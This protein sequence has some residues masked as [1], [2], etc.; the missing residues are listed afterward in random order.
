MG[1]ALPAAVFLSGAAALIYQVCWQRILALHTGIGLFSVAL[2]VGAFMAGL[3]LGSL[4]GGGL[5]ERFERRQALLAFAALELLIGLFG[6]LSV[7]IY[8]DW[9]YLGHAALYGQSWRAVLLHFAALLPPT[10]LMGMSLPFLTRATV[11]SADTAARAVAWVYGINVLGAAFGSV[12]APWWLIRSHGMRT[13]V[14]VAAVANLLAAAA[15]LAAARAPARS[16]AVETTA[17]LV[18]GTRW[19]PLHWMA[20]YALSGFV[21]LSLEM[22]W[23]R[24]LDIAVRATAFTFGTLLAIYLLGNAAGALGARFMKAG[25]HGP[26]A[27]FIACQCALLALSALALAALVYAPVHWPLVSWLADIWDGS[28]SFNLGGAWDGGSVF[29]LYVLLPALLFGLPTILMGV[30]MA[31]LQTAV[32]DDPRTSGFKVGWL[33]AANIAGCVAGALFAGIV[34][35]NSLGTTGTLR[36]LVACAFVFLAFGFRLLPAARRSFAAWAA[37]IAAVLMV[38]PGQDRFWLRFHG[39]MPGRSLVEEDATGVVALTPGRHDTWAMWV[40]GKHFSTLPYGGTH[41]LLGALPSMMHA[42]P[43]RIALI[44]LGSGDTAWASGSRSNVTREIRV[45]EISAPQKAILDRLRAQRLAPRALE[46]FLADPRVSLRVADGRNAI[47]Q[48][49]ELYD[50]IEMDPLRPSNAYSGNLYSREFFALCARKLRPGGF[51][52]TW[53]PSPRVRATFRSVFP[54]VVDFQNSTI[55]VGSLDPFPLDVAAWQA[56]LLEGG[57][58]GYF[59]EQRTAEVRAALATAQ[60]VPFQGAAAREINVDLFPRDEFNTQE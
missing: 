42:R 4:I 7:R 12:A 46:Q 47:E 21:A 44:G 51:M 56:R 43:E 15:A 17:P 50:V 57:V 41:T 52:C 25:G 18:S 11:R 16:R 35:L 34:L 8:Y 19:P 39:E 40:S 23:F 45:F 22:V 20:L 32:H 14:A 6:A 2:I 54:Y 24:V 48:S 1:V 5:S 60:V 27:R 28:R 59:G 3:G 58:S 33:Q 10:L 31:T 30:S 9:L 53:A 37:V 36:V 26:L 38:L 13:A 29:R 49:N 55:L